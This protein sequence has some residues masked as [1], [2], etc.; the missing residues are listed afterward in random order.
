VI[1]KSVFEVVGESTQDMQNFFFHMFKTSQMQ[2][3]ITQ[4]GSKPSVLINDILVR[5]ASEKEHLRIIRSN[6]KEKMSA[7]EKETHA[8]F[9][10]MESLQ[11]VTGS[12]N[13]LHDLMK[14]FRK[15]PKVFYDKID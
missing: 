10:L 14:D 4:S 5:D 6:L 2:K 11:V 9:E 7:P 3:T 1:E 15:N 13:E 8:F 12:G